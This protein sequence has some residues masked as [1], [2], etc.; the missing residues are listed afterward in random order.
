MLDD[1]CPYLGPLARASGLLAPCRALVRCAVCHESCGAT[2]APTAP[3]PALSDH[4]R[5]VSRIRGNVRGHGLRA[6]LDSAA[7]GGLD[8]ARASRAAPS[9]Y[10][11]PSRSEAGPPKLRT[12]VTPLAVDGARPPSPHAA[13]TRH[14]G[15]WRI[16]PAPDGVEGQRQAVRI[17]RRNAAWYAAPPQRRIMAPLCVRSPR[18]GRRGS[19]VAAFRRGPHWNRTSVLFPWR[20]RGRGRSGADADPP[21]WA[22]TPPG[23]QPVGRSAAGCGGSRPRT[24]ADAPRTRLRR[25]DFVS[26]AYARKQPAGRAVM[27]LAV[28]LRPCD[29][30][31]L[32][33]LARTR[34][35]RR[36]YGEAQHIFL[37]P[38]G[39]VGRRKKNVLEFQCLEKRLA[40]VSN[41]W[42]NQAEAADLSAMSIT[43]M[44]VR[45][46]RSGSRL[47]SSS[48]RVHR[49][50]NFLFSS[51]LPPFRPMS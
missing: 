10:V 42:K 47:I 18:R 31:A 49:T 7:V 11:R 35:P 2:F 4:R 40:A 8:D 32:R 3:L 21:R 48:L 16:G 41:G 39:M 51:I 45:C 27:L 26:A 14:G 9:G 37:S 43:C 29:G 36:R 1:G 12:D 17:S 28:A 5:E 38:P 20:W 22:R 25:V 6:P 33:R 44:I 23:V 34:L 13:R 19:H 15:C 46:F 50:G 24:A 30:G